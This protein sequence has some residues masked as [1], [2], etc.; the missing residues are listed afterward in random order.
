MSPTRSR[1]VALARALQRD[2]PL[3][4][5][6]PSEGTRPKS[7]MV[8]PHAMVKA[9][10]G[11]IE[12]ITQ[13]VNGCYEQG[14]YDACAVMMRRLIETLVV[15]T[16]EHHGLADKIKN[17]GG[18]FFHLADLIRAT[19]AEPGWNLGRKTKHAFPRLKDIG[20]QSAHARRFV[21][22]RED[23]DRLQDDFRGIVQEL[24][25]LSGLK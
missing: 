8:I 1:V 23:I 13:Q 25:F 4:Y 3:R 7:E 18:E 10:R 9:T 24:L 20:D 6:P 11:Y 14:W 15:E 22:H 17:P 12:R 19:L 21:A 2:L 5:V 16:F